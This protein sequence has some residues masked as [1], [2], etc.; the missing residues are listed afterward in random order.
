MRL[1]FAVITAMTFITTVAIFA[2]VAF[3]F[4]AARVA[5][6]FGATFMLGCAGAIIAAMTTFATMAFALIAHYFSF[7]NS[8]H[9]RKYTYT[10]YGYLSST[11]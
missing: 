2:A 10:L 6:T 8:N 11:F 1:A 3:M 4:A 7:Q 5:L 9:E